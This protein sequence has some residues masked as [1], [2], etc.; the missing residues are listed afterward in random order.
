MLKQHLLVVHGLVLDPAVRL[1]GSPTITP[2][3]VDDAPALD[4][5]RVGVTRVVGNI[6]GHDDGGEVHL[7][8]LTEAGQRARAALR[9]LVA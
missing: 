6:A 1:P 3:I 9:P 2:I 7:P 5:L 8:R 4:G